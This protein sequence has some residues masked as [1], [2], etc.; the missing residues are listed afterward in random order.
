[1]VVLQLKSLQIIADKNGSGT[2][3]RDEICHLLG[4]V[5]KKN[6]PL[7]AE[8]I[9]GDDSVDE[10]MTLVDKSHS[11][12]ITI[13]NFM[14]AV[15]NGLTLEL[16]PMEENTTPSYPIP[17]STR[18]SDSNIHITFADDEDEIV[19][20]QHDLLFVESIKLE[21]V[22]QNLLEQYHT[23][24]MTDKRYERLRIEEV[25]S[26]GLIISGA[27]G[28]INDLIALEGIVASNS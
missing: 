14:A 22:A 12:K 26:V 9:I 13:G 1:M 18:K 4:T 27:R 6:S 17:H 8:T 2:L 7:L 25:L 20:P 28:I 19:S 16:E 11:G 15:E 3:N 5:L 24:L 10:F 23:W 21:E